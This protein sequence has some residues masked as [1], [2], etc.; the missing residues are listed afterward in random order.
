MKYLVSAALGALGGFALTATGASAAIVCNEDGDCWHVKQ[1]YEYRPEFGVQ[2]YNDDWSG[3]TLK[4]I[5]I[6]GASTRVV[7]TGVR[8]FGSSSKAFASSPKKQ[9]LHKRP[10]D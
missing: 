5:S 8:A 1:K 2:V 10:Q 4:P 3:P 9:D 7:A 6:G